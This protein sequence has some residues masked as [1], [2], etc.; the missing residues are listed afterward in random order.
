[1]ERPGHLR[2]I[3]YC[4][5]L[6]PNLSGSVPPSIH[7]SLDLPRLPQGTRPVRHMAPVN[8]ENKKG[9]KKKGGTRNR[10][11]DSDEENQLN[12]EIEMQIQDEM[13]KAL[14]GDSVSDS[15]SG[16]GVQPIWA[17]V[18]TSIRDKDL[19]SLAPV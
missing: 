13:E 5:T 2:P 8:M 3:P 1:M 6:L 7:Y 12:A 18:F 9:N 10:Q 16:V 4:L 19:T 15:V 17:A 14:E 11:V